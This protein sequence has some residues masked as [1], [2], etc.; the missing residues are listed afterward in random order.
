MGILSLGDGFAVAFL[1]K[2]VECKDSQGRTI[3]AEEIEQGRKSFRRLRKEESPFRRW[4]SSAYSNV[5]VTGIW[6]RTT[7]GF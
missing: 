4:P 1:Q 3:T 2:W 7:T 6:M 5:Q